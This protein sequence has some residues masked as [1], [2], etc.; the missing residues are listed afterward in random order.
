MVGK[1]VCRDDA[2]AVGGKYRI[3][4]ALLSQ[5]LQ[6]YKAVVEG[7]QIPLIAKEIDTGGLHCVA[8]DQKAMFAVQQRD[9]ARCVSRHPNDLQLILANAEGV[10]L[11][12]RICLR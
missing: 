5:R 7:G 1:D 4:S 3:K 9:A 6:F 12:Q 10:S 2:L 8:G 11:L